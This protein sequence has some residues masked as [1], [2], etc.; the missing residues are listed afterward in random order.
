[1]IKPTVWKNKKTGELRTVI[2]ILGFNDW[3]AV[4][5]PTAK[6]R[7]KAELKKVM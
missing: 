5:N 1:M 3:V 7:K 6:Q 2:P 4:K